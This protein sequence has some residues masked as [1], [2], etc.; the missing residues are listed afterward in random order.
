[1]SSAQ[2]QR[3]STRLRRT[4]GVAASVAALVALLGPRRLRHG[5]GR[6]VRGAARLSI[7]RLRGRG[8]PALEKAAQ[9]R[10]IDDGWQA[11]RQKQSDR[12]Q[13]QRGPGRH[14]PRVQAARAPVRDRCRSQSDS[15]ARR[16]HGHRARLR[17]C[18]A[19]TV[20]GGRRG[21][22]TKAL[23]S[24][25]PNAGPRPVAR[26]S[27]GSTDRSRSA[28]AGS[29]IGSRPRAHSTGRGRPERRAHAPSH[30]HW[31]RPGQPQ[32][33]P[34]AGPVARSRWTGSTRAEAVLS[35]L[36]RDREVVLLSGNIAESRGDAAPPS[37]STRR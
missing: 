31:T 29:T 37:A 10:N 24:G 30:R 33:G 22:T 5:S 13:K 11:L 4:A 21:R 2:R 1:M 19:D 14:E 26:I 7:A 15:R 25:P 32:R 6:C 28:G 18:L 16:A 8:D 17:G 34:A 9:R 3:R 20:G 35:G 12:C 23:H 27:G 36:P